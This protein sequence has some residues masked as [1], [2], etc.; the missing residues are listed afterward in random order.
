M[1]RT[2]EFLKLAGEAA[3][4]PLPLASAPPP[5]PQLV[6]PLPLSRERTQQAKYFNQRAAEVSKGISNCSVLLA[7]LTVL[8]RAQTLFK[9]SDESTILQ[10]KV[11]SEMKI[12][13]TRL[14]E[15][16]QWLKQNDLGQG[17][18]LKKHSEQVVKVMEFKL[19]D[20]GKQFQQVLETRKQAL[21][22]QGQRKKMFG[23]DPF[24]DM[25][26]GVPTTSSAGASRSGVLEEEEEERLLL[27]NSRQQDP[28]MM[29]TSESMQFSPQRQLIPDAQYL[30]S[31]VD[32]ITTVESHIAELGQVM[33]TLASMVSE[34]DHLVDRFGDNV[35]GIQMDIRGGFLQ[36]EK[37]YDS[38]R[39]NKR[40]VSRL[41]GV[42]VAFLFFFL[43]FLA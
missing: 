19:Q 11:N 40:L 13:K 8:A 41:F 1:D 34:Q 10:V 29:M 26:I 43:F 6:A 28:E 14:A 2:R 9:D 22:Q 4:L 12:L 17:R 3:V 30:R 35:D 31:R 38:I 39:G 20:S 15:L 21:K 32:A 33:S 25:D 42:V 7:R 16:E 24:D 27:S 37:Y 18:D 23:E 5:A 36:L